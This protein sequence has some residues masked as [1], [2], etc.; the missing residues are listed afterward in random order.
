MDYRKIITIEPGKRSG[1]PC[2]HGMRITVGDVLGYLAAGMSHSEIL[3]DF[4]ELTEEDILTCLTYAAD[5]ERLTTILPTS[6]C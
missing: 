6:A 1:K 5:R 2:I 4:D 3:A